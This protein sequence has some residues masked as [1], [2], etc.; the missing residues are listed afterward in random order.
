MDEQV[1]SLSR[2]VS[3]L[4]SFNRIH[5]VVTS[6]AVAAVVVVGQLPPIWADGNGP[7]S[8]SAEEFVL[9]DH[10]GRTTATLRQTSRELSLRIQMD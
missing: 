7:K 10:S 8:F 2:R 3:R 9:V 6:L 1:S 5:I 4:E